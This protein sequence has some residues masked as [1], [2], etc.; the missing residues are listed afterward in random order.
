MRSVKQREEVRW[1]MRQF[2]VPIVL[3]ALGAAP[4]VA[5]GADQ[6]S[7]KGHPPSSAKVP[8]A[9]A[10]A[11]K[12]VLPVRATAQAS[13]KAGPAGAQADKPDRPILQFNPKGG[14]NPAQ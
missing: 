10:S 13:R 6:P 3:L 5:I 11:E 1:M 14:R 8:Q 9:A 2:F 4:I 12:P 7:V